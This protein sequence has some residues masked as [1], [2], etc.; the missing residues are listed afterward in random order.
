VF[1]FVMDGAQG[2]KCLGEDGTTVRDI[3]TGK[4]KGNGKQQEPNIIYMSESTMQ[5][6]S[7]M[8]GEC[9]LYVILSSTGI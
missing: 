6:L 4:W 5:L 9:G 8:V 3:T 1:W 7:G 2:N